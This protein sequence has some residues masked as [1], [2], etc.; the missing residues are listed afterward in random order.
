MPDVLN[1]P[2]DIARDKLKES[3]LVM[4]IVDYVDS[5]TVEKDYVLSQDIPEGSVVKKYSTVDVYVSNGSDLV[6]LTP[7]NLIGMNGEAAKLLL[8]QYKLKPVLNQ[9]AHDS[10]PEEIGRAH[11]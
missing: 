1:L 2:V 7:L 5:D 8:E 9:E 4:N 10:I 6:D 11:V 3:T